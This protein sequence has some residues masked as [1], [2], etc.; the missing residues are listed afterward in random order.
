[1]LSTLMLMLLL[2]MRFQTPGCKTGEGWEF[3]VRGQDVDKNPRWLESSEA[4]P[5]SARAAIRAGRAVL[6]QMSCNEP[7]QWGLEN[8]ALRPVLGEQDV[9]VYIVTFVEPAVLAGPSRS[10]FDEPP[11]GGS[12]CPARRHGL[13]AVSRRLAAQ[14]LTC[15]PGVV[16]RCRLSL[17]ITR[18]VDSDM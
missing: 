9:W 1:M 10:R 2:Q 13:D 3:V 8:V 17:R 6:R 15:I 18:A 4:P 5:L 11:D 7:E 12:S 14:A 16:L